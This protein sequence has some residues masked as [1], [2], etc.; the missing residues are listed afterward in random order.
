ML[1]TKM[2]DAINEQINW[3][4]YSGYLY[5]SMAAQ[6][7]QLGMPGGQN[8]MTVQYQEELAHAQ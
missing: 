7:S 2:Q 4:F 1:D 3:E 5:L 6:F 8:W